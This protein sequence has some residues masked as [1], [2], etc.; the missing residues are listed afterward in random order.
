MIEQI[1][2]LLILLVL[3]Y[4]TF[5]RSDKPATTLTLAEDKK[6]EMVEIVKREFGGVHTIHK[7]PRGHKDEHEA[8]GDP[9]LG[10]R[11]EDGTIDW[12]NNA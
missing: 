12:G 11:Y 5:K 3:L 6:T 9:H 10:V 4:Q 8:L 7:V 2:L 1:L